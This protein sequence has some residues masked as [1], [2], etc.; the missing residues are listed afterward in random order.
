MK[1]ISILLLL[2]LLLFSCVKDEGN[3]DYLDESLV[4][5]GEVTGIENTYNVN[6]LQNLQISPEVS[7]ITN[8]D[9]FDYYWIVWGYGINR[10]SW[11]DTISRERS[12]DYVVNLSSGTY[13][14]AFQA[15]NKETGV[16]VYHISEM[17]VASI[18]SRGWY[19]TKTVEGG[20]ELDFIEKDGIFHENV[21]QTVNGECVSGE[22]LKSFY[23]S[24]QYD[25]I[26]ENPNGTVTVLDNQKVF[27]VLSENDM[28]VYNADNMQ[29]FKKYEDAFLEVPTVHAPQDMYLGMSGQ[30]L[31]NNKKLHWI[32]SLV[33]GNTSRFGFPMLG[34]YE[35]APFTMGR[36]NGG[37]LVFDLK[38]HSYKYAPYSQTYLVDL[39]TENSMQDCNN[40]DYDL[41][42]MDEQTAYYNLTTGGI[43]LMKHRDKE[44]YVG[45]M[46]NTDWSS[47]KN[48]FA[49]FVKVPDGCVVGKGK[50]FATNCTNDVL[51]FSDGGNTV[52]MY[53]VS[54]GIEKKA[55][56]TYPLEESVAYIRHMSYINYNGDP[57][58]DCLA[59]LTNTSS[60]WNLYLYNFVGKTADVETPHYQKYSGTG[61]AKH[62]FYRGLYS[63]EIN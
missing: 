35:V 7:R 10:T 20:T 36:M 62:V 44:E 25:H 48:P 5:L 24:Q 51:Y 19:V 54:N 15:K 28:R 59:V 37:I 52:G 11:K 12:L 6:S 38:T 14:L 16:S 29:L 53:N 13:Q 21:L 40:M 47:G 4:S 39:K 2:S 55:I 50:V 17:I 32:R 46:L 23:Q 43:A 9:E 30:F 41:V 26:Q 1:K 8:D 61:V 34:D 3:Y 49:K 56:I 33:S 57:T 45:I 18:Y 27:Y 60:G 31:I 22:A 63:Q 58:V 42:F